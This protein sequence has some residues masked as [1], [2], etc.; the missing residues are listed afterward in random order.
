PSAL[1]QAPRPLAHRT[2]PRSVQALT[3]P[4]LAIEPTPAL[5]PGSSQTKSPLHQDAAPFPLRQRDEA[6]AL[7]NPAVITG[8]SPMQ[9]TL[10][11]CGASA[12]PWLCESPDRE[13]SIHSAWMC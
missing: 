8:L 11:Q 6:A 13:A 5:E 10:Q 7:L 3:E 1:I 9:T 12:A 2:S 4:K